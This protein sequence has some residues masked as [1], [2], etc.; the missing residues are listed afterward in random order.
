MVK[1]D[2]VA[3]TQAKK[4]V[5]TLRLGT[6]IMSCGLTNE[7]LKLASLFL[8][9]AWVLSND[10]NIVTSGSSPGYVLHRLR[11]QTLQLLTLHSMWQ[12][13]YDGMVERCL[14]FTATDFCIATMLLSSLL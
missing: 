4:K 9:E 13:D 2:V 5:R 3:T 11:Y 1:D 14:C 10:S 7:V 12:M 6:P 8:V